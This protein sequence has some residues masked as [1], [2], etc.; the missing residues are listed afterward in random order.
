MKKRPIRKN[1]GNSFGM[2]NKTQRTSYEGM[3]QGNKH[4]ASGSQSVHQSINQTVS[5]SV[6][7]I[8]RPNRNLVLVI[9]ASS[10]ISIDLSYCHHYSAP[11]PHQWSWLSLRCC[12]HRSLLLS[13]PLSPVVVILLVTS[14]C[15][16]RNRLRR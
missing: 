1:G 2:I 13:S 16:P 14:R 8:S 15:H 12:Y 4:K 11:L 7:L 3:S 5:N 9:F 6:L 10:I